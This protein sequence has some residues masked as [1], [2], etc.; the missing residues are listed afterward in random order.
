LNGY[1][2]WKNGLFISVPS[3]FDFWDHYFF[4]IALYEPHYTNATAMVGQAVCYP[5]WSEETTR[6]KLLAPVLTE[7]QRALEI[8]AAPGV[9]QDAI[10]DLELIQAA[11]IEGL[12][13]AFELLEG[14]LRQKAG[15]TEL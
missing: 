13:P 7:Y 1:L 11:G 2:V 10:R 5:N 12:G 4:G 15:S 8:C 6:P 14:A 9:V 3:L